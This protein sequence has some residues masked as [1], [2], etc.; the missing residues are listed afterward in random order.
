MNNAKFPNTEYNLYLWLKA[1]FIP[2]L[3]LCPNKKSRYDCTSQKFKIDVE[4]KCRKVHYDKLLIEKK[5]YD[6][7]INR[8]KKEGTIPLY[9]NS[10][11]KGI[12]AFYLQ[13]VEIDWEIKMMPKHTFFKDKESIEKIVGYL[14]VNSSVDL[15][16]LKKVM[17]EKK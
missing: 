13:S 6:A 2:D 17:Y 10:T 15:V 14:D 9:I 5:K 4:L 7:L 16:G 8:S 3:I 1:Y 11:P 12:Y